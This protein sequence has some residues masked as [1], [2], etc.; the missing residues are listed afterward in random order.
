MKITKWIREMSRIKHYLKGSK[1]SME[2]A[3]K[4]GIYVCTCCDG[5]MPHSPKDYNI[6]PHCRVEFGYD[7]PESDSSPILK[8]T[9]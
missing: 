1:D 6:C 9:D 7:A 2:Q 5:W 8:G 4:N 3:K